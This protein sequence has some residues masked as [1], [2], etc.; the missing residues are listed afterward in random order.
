MHWR[1][2]LFTGTSNSKKKK[3][4]CRI[5]TVILTWVQILTETPVIP[6]ASGT[7]VVHNNP[8]WMHITKSYT[9]FPFSMFS[10]EHWFIIWTTFSVTA[11]KTKST[12]D[13][14]V[15]SVERNRSTH[16]FRSLDASNENGILNLRA[17]DM[18]TNYMLLFVRIPQ[19]Q[20]IAGK[21]MPNSPESN[22]ELDSIHNIPCKSY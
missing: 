20:G 12:R 19:I 7:K 6:Y 21:R 18:L 11:A 4:S 1:T 10:S 3:K 14:C 17:K 9:V 5:K 13:E 22:R 15:S 8:Y 16:C 2:I